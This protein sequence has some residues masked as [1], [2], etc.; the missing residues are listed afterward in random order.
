MTPHP[1]RSYLLAL[2][3]LPVLIGGADRVAS[4]AGAS[5]EQ[6]A[7]AAAD[8]LTLEGLLDR[9]V[10]ARGG[11]PAMDS[12]RNLEV[13]FLVVEPKFALEGRYRAT[14]D[15]RVRVD[16]FAGDDNVY[17]E[18]IDSAGAWMREGVDAPIE[19]LSAEGT[20][21]LRHG[22]EFNLVGLHRFPD[23]GH[24][25]AYEGREPVEGTRYHV[26]HA[27]LQD[28][29][30][31]RLYVDPESWLV[32]RRRDRRALH[33]DQDSTEQQLETVFHD[34]EDVCGVQRA[35]RS[36]QIDLATGDTVQTTRVIE[37]LCN[38]APTELDITRDA[39]P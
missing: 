30:E 34:F 27:T 4:S 39:E 14:R 33:P 17:S 38:R 26:I 21:A 2:A 13:R 12:L 7:P 10:E 19:P 5:H 22:I 23:R 35:T 16:A 36:H 24:R 11:R 3:A 18:G 9:H 32:T 15:G 37:Q 31:A 28:G 1:F 8:T 20:A 29:F 25:L 6:Q